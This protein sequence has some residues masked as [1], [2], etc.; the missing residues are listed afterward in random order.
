VQNVF[1]HGVLEQDVYMRQPPRYEDSSYLL[2]VCKL[3]K[4][5]YGLKQALKAWYS[6][7][8]LKLT[9]LGVVIPKADTSLFI[10]NK[11]SIIIYLLIYVDDIIVTSSSSTVV[12]ALLRDLSSDFALKDLIN[13][14]YFLGIQV[15][16]S[17]NGFLLSQELYASEILHKVGMSNC[18]PVKTPLAS[19]EKLS[20]NNGKLLSKEEATKYHGIV[21]GLQYLTLTRLDISFTVNK[22]CQFLHKPTDLHMM[23]VK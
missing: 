22:V 12:I 23:A 1:L 11:S 9:K 4:A 6:R 15:T 16:R 8:S 7:L 13:L 5:L 10:Y 3:D 21:G 17:A 2:H 18:K 19:S 14:S 20:I